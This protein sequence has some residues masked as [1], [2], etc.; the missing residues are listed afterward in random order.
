MQQTFNFKHICDAFEAI[1]PYLM[2]KS[3]GKTS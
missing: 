2:I 3:I 1:K